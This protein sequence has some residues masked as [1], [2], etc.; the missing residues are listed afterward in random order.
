[1]RYLA[2]SA[3]VLFA[4][5]AIHPEPEDVTGL[6]TPGI[7]KQIRCETRD[8]ARMV[9]LKELER[10]ATNSDNP[11]AQNLFSLYTEDQNRMSSFDP[12][13]AFPEPRYK[14]IRNYFNLIYSAAAAYSFVL[15][16]NEENDF[17][18]T[19]N[20]LGQWQAKFMLGIVGDLDRTRENQRQFTITDKFSVL[21]KELNTPDPSGAQYCDGHIALGPNYVY[22]IAGHI[23]IYNT[24]WTFFQLSIFE[25]AAAKGA[26]PGGAGPPALA[27][28]LTFTTT[29]DVTPSPKFVFAPVKTAFQITDASQS[30]GLLR[31]KDTHQ[32]TVAVALQPSGTAVL[33]SLQGYVFSGAGLPGTPVSIGR[34]GVQTL[35]LNRITATATSGA[36]Q[37]ALHAIDQVQS[38]QVQLLPPPSP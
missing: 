12:N 26:S 36:E 32:V 18:A 30:A 27:D 6:D 14:Q 34:P 28:Q 20:F 16:M 23:G 8:A 15:T 37:V 31:R 35:M 24:V 22:P 19:T 17:G 4:G 9:I 29:I 13:L 38:R 2:L 7:V 11:T 33:S 5:C 1:M 21:L 3:S 25:S 10:L